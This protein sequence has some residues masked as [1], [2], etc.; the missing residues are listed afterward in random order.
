MGALVTDE[1]G[2]RVFLNVGVY[3]GERVGVEVVGDFDGACVVGSA[4]Q[5]G[6]RVGA[7]G[8]NVGSLDGLCV[9][10][11]VG[12]TV[13]VEN[14]GLAV[15]TLVVGLSVGQIDLIEHILVDAVH[16]HPVNERQFAATAT[17]IQ[18]LPLSGN[19][20]I[21]VGEA[22]GREVGSAVGVLV[23]I[24]VGFFVGLCVGCGV[25][26]FNVGSLVGAFVGKEVVGVRVGCEVVG[27][28]EGSGVV[29]SFVGENVG[30][31]MHLLDFH[32]QPSTEASQIAFVRWFVQ[33][34]CAYT[35]ANNNT[36]TSANSC[37]GIALCV[38]LLGF[39]SCFGKANVCI[40]Y[41]G[42]SRDR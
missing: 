1:V 6:L 27:L 11:G 4:V 30:I 21:G 13:G 8:L 26:G 23:G 20:Q 37:M 40:W 24:G 19:T 39:V 41:S 25:L 12:D 7:N 10:G 9:V 16:S 17:S 22:V 42:R 2:R 34:G 15:G 33:E 31:A 14:V 35:T 36:R 32:S 38:W 28:C 18:A 5:F 3:V 29:G